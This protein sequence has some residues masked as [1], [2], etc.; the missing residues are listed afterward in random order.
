VAREL[1]AAAGRRGLYAGSAEEL[2]P[3]RGD[4]IAAVANAGLGAALLAWPALWREL[5]SG[6]VS[7]YALTP[8]AWR[9]I[10]AGRGA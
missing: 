2:T 10:R 1:V 8:E 6:A 9:A 4:P 5:S 3:G 7:A